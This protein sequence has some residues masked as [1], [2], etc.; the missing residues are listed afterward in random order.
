MAPLFNPDIDNLM[1]DSEDDDFMSD[2]DDGEFMFDSEEEERYWERLR[3]EC[4]PLAYNPKT[5]E[6]KKELKKIYDMTVELITLN[7][8]QDTLTPEEKLR[9]EELKKLIPIKL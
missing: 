5:E 3:D 2:S 7:D 8:R 9:F 4:G 6:Q 1:P